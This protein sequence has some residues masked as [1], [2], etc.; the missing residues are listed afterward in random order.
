MKVLLCTPF[1]KSPKAN[2]GGISVWANNLLDYARVREDIDKVRLIP[3]SY[4]RYHRT[5]SGLNPFLRL[6]YGFVDINK[7]IKKTKKVLKEADIDV[8]HV[9]S[10]ASFSLLKD[11]YLLFLAKKHRLKYIVHFHFGLIPELEKKNNFEWKLLRYVVKRADKVVVMTMESY[12]T[13]K[14]I[15]IASVDYLPNPVSE[16]IIRLVS[17]W[18]QG[19]TRI[20]GRIVYVGH[21]VPNKG[22]KEIIE[23][24]L[25]ISGLDVHLIGEIPSSDYIESLK[26]LFCNGVSETCISF[27]G[28]SS[29]EDVIK[30]LLKAEI[31]VFPSYYEGFPNAILEAMAC[32]CPIIAS[33]VGAIP[34]MLDIDKSPCGV[35]VAPQD[36]QAVKEAIVLLH[37]D[38]EYRN[39]LAS[40]AKRRVEN[41]YSTARIWNNLINIW[42]A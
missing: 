42:G 7:S 32:G 12:K 5:G 24:C 4:D 23:S 39:N 40:K 34:E 19:S 16:K 15:G 20:P 1:E 17:E 14:K 31:F 27:L 30:E 35:C 2:W 9:C 11:I 41:E 37:K 29:Q 3:V 8:L 26:P 33:S 13:L 10:S 38:S 36:T 6:W 18:S 22:I 25:S 28:K 21:I